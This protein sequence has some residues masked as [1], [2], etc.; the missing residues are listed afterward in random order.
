MFGYCCKCNEGQAGY[1]GGDG[2]GSGSGGGLY[3]NPYGVGGGCEICS[4][5]PYALT[6][7]LVMD[8]ACPCMEYGGT[9]TLNH[10]GSNEIAP[11][12]ILPGP[13]LIIPC[14]YWI[15]DEKSKDEFTCATDT[16]PRVQVALFL[17]NFVYQWQ[18]SIRYKSGIG[19]GYA[20]FYTAFTDCFQSLTASAFGYDAFP[21]TVTSAQVDP[22]T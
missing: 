4:T 11:H 16:I 3:F 20:T 15:S 12:P 17:D 21:C 22:A 1:Y 5:V 8:V 13:G 10:A 6:I 9:F 19:S 2:S 18:I 7:D 14:D